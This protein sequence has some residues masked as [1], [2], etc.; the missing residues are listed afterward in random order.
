MQDANEEGAPSGTA[1]ARGGANGGVKGGVTSIAI[2]TIVAVVAV[3]SYFA[4]QTDR[5][6]ETS[7][8]I[9][10]CA[11]TLAVA[12]A[13]VAIAGRRSALWQQL[14]P[15]AG[16]F[17]VG[18]FGAGVLFAGAYGFVRVVMPAGSP[19]AMWLARIYLQTGDPNVLRAHPAALFVALIVVAAAEEIVWRGV[20]TSLLAEKIGERFAW[21]ASAALYA[22]AYVPT[23]WSLK[24]P[25]AGLDPLLPIA[26]LFAGLGW[27]WMVK[28]F[29]RL[30]PAIVAHA[31]FDWAVIVM[32]RLWG[33]SL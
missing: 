21:A 22:L 14:K 3:T 19:R 33:E 8:W 13:S 9:L 7:F 12:L 6:G 24:S 20:V 5:A 31:L 25:S 4:F 10:A 1:D 26:A 30:P 18:F 28:R 32:F 16:D 29:D 23:M 27:G 17:S 2:G 11:P 15:K